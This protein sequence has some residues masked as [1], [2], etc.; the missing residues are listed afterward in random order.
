[1]KWNKND[2]DDNITVLECHEIKLFIS[3]IE[4]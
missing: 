1:M 3:L 2:V 4:W